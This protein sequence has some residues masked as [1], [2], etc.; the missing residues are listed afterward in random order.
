MATTSDSAFQLLASR[1]RE[2]HEAIH[3]PSTGSHLVLANSD[4]PKQN[5]WN[6][7]A[8]VYHTASIQRK[9][10]LQHGVLL[11]GRPKTAFTPL[12][13]GYAFPYYDL[14]CK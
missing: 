11:A 6:T 1:H 2:I 13:T 9:Q 8:K 10:T 5:F 4:A 3:R 12:N 14:A 7:D